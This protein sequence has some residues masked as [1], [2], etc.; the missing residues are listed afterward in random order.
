[1]QKRITLENS[2]LENA[3]AAFEKLK[4]ELR[5]MDYVGSSLKKHFC[6]VLT[7]YR[8]KR[9]T[10]SPSD[11]SRCKQLTRELGNVPLNKFADAFDVYIRVLRNTPTIKTKRLPSNASVNRFVEIVMAAFNLCLALKVVKENPISKFRFP[12]LKEKPRDRYLSIEERQRLFN[13]I[14]KH[15]PYILPFVRYSLLVPTRKNELT[16]LTRDAY[17]SFTNTLYIPDSKAGIPIHKPVPEEMKDYFLNGIPPG[18]P[19]IFWRQRIKDKKYLP[20]GDFRKAFLKCVNKAGLVNVRIHDFRHV[21][22]TDLCMVG[23]SER[24][25]MDIA[26]WKTPMLST[27]WHK[28]SLRSAQT[29]RFYPKCENT[30]KTCADEAQE[31]CCNS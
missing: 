1:V 25:I 29:I 11:I 27:Y 2:T 5:G 8:E 30:V 18:C 12:K 21:A 24:A 17:N 9:N 13:A 23:N 22:A 19:W 16:H 6:E 7:I 3:K 26:G 28:D 31:K 20:L 10:L 4:A 14:E 15:A